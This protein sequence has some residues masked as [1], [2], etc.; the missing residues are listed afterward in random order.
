MTR[1]TAWPADL[2]G[3][4]G[5][6]K[7]N[8]G[9]F[10][11]V[12]SSLIL[13][14]LALAV[15]CV[16]SFA[17]FDEKSALAVLASDS[18]KKARACQALAV[19][20]GPDSVPALAEFLGNVRLASYARTALEV[21]DDPSAGEALR[22]ALPKLEGRLLAGVI[23]SLGVRGDQAAVPALQDL[24]TN[25]DKRVADSAITALA[26]VGTEDALATVVQALRQGPADLRISAAHAA[27]SAAEKMTAQGN[28]NAARQLL[29]SVRAAVIPEHIKQAAQG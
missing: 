19:Y 23:T 1:R 25:P 27:L 20:G 28:K 17:K 4:R 26:R 6:F 9:I 11:K 3:I 18:E 12:L 13:P 10:M 7:T 29:E 2:A 15:F 24:T 8:I 16:N 22:A 21:I 14:L 5:T